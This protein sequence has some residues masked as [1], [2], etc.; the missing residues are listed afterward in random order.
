MSTRYDLHCKIPCL[1][2]IFLKLKKHKVSSSPSP[3]PSCHGLIIKN[4]GLIEMIASTEKY[5]SLLKQFLKDLS[6]AANLVSEGVE[7]KKI[8]LGLQAKSQLVG[9]GKKLNSTP[10]SAPKK[11]SKK[12]INDNNLLQNK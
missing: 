8:S 9:F 1:Q 7:S 3:P 12:L 6:S 11:L 5:L 10:N 2:K 4:S